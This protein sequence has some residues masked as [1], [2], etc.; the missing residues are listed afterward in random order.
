[1]QQKQ[2]AIDAAIHSCELWFRTKNDLYNA[3]LQTMQRSVNFLGHYIENGT[4]SP[5][6]EKTKAVRE[7]KTPSNVKAVQAFLGLTGFFRKFIKSYSIIARPL[8]DL[9]KNEAKFN[10]GESELNAINVLKEALVREPVLKLYKRGAETELH[11][12]ASKEGFGAAL[13]QRFEGKMHPVCFWSKKTSQAESSMH[14]YILEAKAVY[15]SVKK[16]RVYLLG[17]QFKLVTDCI[18]FKQTL[19]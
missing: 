5:G 2:G 8:T 7:F 12:D 16:F 15:L 4:V 6:M 18:A 14:S 19:K 3:M 17:I 9:L 1:M 13:L 11:T 10:I